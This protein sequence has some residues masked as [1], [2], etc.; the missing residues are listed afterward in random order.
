MDICCAPGVHATP[1]EQ[2]LT[3]TVWMN[4]VFN[5][6]LTQ[7]HVSFNRL[8]ST[9]RSYLGLF[10][11]HGQRVFVEL[12]GRWQLL[13]LPSAF[14]IQPRRVSLD[15]STCRWTDRGSC[16]GAQRSA[17]DSSAALR[18][19][20]GEPVRFLIT[21]HIALNGDDGT[22]RQTAKLRAARQRHL[23]RAGGQRPNCSERFPGGGFVIV[24]DAATRARAASAA[25][26]CCSTIGNRVTSRSCVWSPS[27]RRRS[28]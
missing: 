18:V 2:A 17:R 1:D 15:L 4:G 24:P 28:V 21:H 20:V 11:S 13:D 22:T 26:S 19:L 6:M 3:S 9:T 5:S 25:M 27:V 10:R 7:G 14:E 16:A 8:L 12:Q 23:H